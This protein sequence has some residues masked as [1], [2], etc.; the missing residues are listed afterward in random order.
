MTIYSIDDSAGWPAMPAARTMHSVTEWRDAESDDTAPRD[1]LRLIAAHTTA[2]VLYVVVDGQPALR[3]YRSTEGD[4][5]VTYTVLSPED[6]HEW[7]VF[8]FRCES[9][10]DVAGFDG[11]LSTLRWHRPQTPDRSQLFDRKAS[12]SASS[13]R[14]S[15]SRSSG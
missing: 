8:E 9:R 1:V 10:H 15:A 5:H 2:A 4:V 3:E 6:R 14:A 11:R 13:R 12:A 7:F